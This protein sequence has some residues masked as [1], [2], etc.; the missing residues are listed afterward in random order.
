MRVC[1]LGCVC[2]CVRVC[3]GVRVCVMCLYTTAIYCNGIVCVI[4]GLA[5][6][7]ILVPVPRNAQDF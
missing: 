4:L 5:I 7:P 3:E 2:A 1:V 6:G